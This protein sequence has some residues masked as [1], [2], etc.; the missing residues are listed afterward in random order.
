MGVPAHVERAGDAGLRPV[1]ADRLCRRGD[2]IVVEGEPERRAAMPRR[3]ERDPLLWYRRIGMLGIVG[4]DQPGNVDKIGR[5][6]RLACALM[7]S[8]RQLLPWRLHAPIGPSA[9]DSRLQLLVFP[10]TSPA[11]TGSARAPNC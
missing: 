9:C 11:A 6:G 4:G 2:V 5:P 7:N 1:L 8:H 3:A 10:Q